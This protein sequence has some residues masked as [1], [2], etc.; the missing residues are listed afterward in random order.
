WIGSTPQPNPP[1]DNWIDFFRVHRLERLY[2]LCRDQGFALPAGEALLENLPEF[3]KEHQP[4][5]SL[6]HGDLWSGNAAFDLNGEPFLF[7]PASYY[8]DRETDLAF[9]EFFGGFNSDFY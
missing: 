3:F 5:P 2:R 6:L 8:G 4:W 7:D 9:T 1:S